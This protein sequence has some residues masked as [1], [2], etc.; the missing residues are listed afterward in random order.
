MIFVGLLIIIIVSTLLGRGTQIP[1]IKSD[2]SYIEMAFFLFSSASSR[3]NLLDNK[4]LTVNNSSHHIW[5]DGA[6]NAFIA[7]MASPS[8]ALSNSVALLLFKSNWSTY[9]H[10][11]KAA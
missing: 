2:S 6:M 3:I 1:S 4:T 8:W 10:V 5:V 9:S 11:N 7:L